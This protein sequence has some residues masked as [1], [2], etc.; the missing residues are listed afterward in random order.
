MASAA[1][2]EPTQ[3]DQLVI[4]G[5]G[6]AGLSL[7]IQ[8]KQRQP[9]LAI[10]VIEREKHPVTEAAHKVGESLVELSSH[11]F[12]EVLGL[13]QHLEEKQLPKLG[14]RFFFRPDPDQPADERLQKTIEFG[15]KKF[16]S[17]A[18][19]QLDRGIF[20]NHLA[21]V[22]Q[23]LGVIFIDNKKVIDIQLNK[24]EQDHQ[25]FF[26]DLETLEKQQINCRWVVDAC[27][28]KSPIKRQQGL[29]IESPHKV[30]S[31][32]FRIAQKLDVNTL[33]HSKEWLEDHQ[34]DNSRWFS[35]NHFMGEGYWLWFIPLASGST[36]IGIVAENDRHPL[37]SFNTLDK[38]L[39]WL[40]KHEPLAASLINKHIDALQDFRV[41]KNFS[42]DCEQVFNKNRWFLTGEAGAFLDP[43]Y[44]PGSDFIAISNT[45]ICHLI[46]TDINDSLSFATN[47]LMLDMF[48]LN[49][50]KNTSVIYQDLYPVFNHPAI[51]PIKILWDFSVYW[52]FTAF[53]YIQGQFDNTESLFKQRRHFEDIGVMN[54][55]IQQLFKLWAEQ[56]P[57]IA[58]PL[59][60]DPFNIDF[61]KNLNQGLKKD[62]ADDDAFKQQF[63]N[64][65][66]GLKSLYQMI[67][68]TAYQRH[69]ELEQQ[70]APCAILSEQIE[71]IA[72]VESM[73]D[74][75]GQLLPA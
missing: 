20:E 52:S 74:L 63:L 33:N 37:A 47:C 5:G 24:K 44:S 57:A 17:C 39:Q 72:E 69:P 51:M 45:F 59:Y 30:S 11:Y 53:L 60:I 27:S 26:Q 48:Y 7:A 13:K 12:S 15:A 61:L 35:T 70:I 71:P 75:L 67:C 18:S 40:E 50:F 10:T 16:P 4:L 49:L 9:Q 1:A 23:D 31:A 21:E 68:K 54:E 34:G 66:Q 32:W 14:L 38:A 58:N 64:N 29:D 42:H 25:V 65:I 19:Y 41:L 55:Q 46:D 8:L 6:L 62:F 36:S 43:F 3:T 2:T 22:C 56:E 73:A 28:R